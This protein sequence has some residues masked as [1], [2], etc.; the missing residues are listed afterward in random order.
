VLFNFGIQAKYASQMAPGIPSDF[1]WIGGAY[2]CIQPDAG[3]YQ[4][5]YLQIR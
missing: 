2:Q 5:A 1:S 3:P 4:T